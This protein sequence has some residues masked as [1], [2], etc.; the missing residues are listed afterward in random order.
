MYQFPGNR[1]VYLSLRRFHFPLNAWLSALHRIT[2]L[3][4]VICLIG[5]LMLLNLLTFHPLVTLEAI[6]DHWILQCLHTT[7]WIS[8]SYHWLAGLRHLL[9]E[10]FT[11]AAHYAAINSKTVSRIMLVVWSALSLLSCYAVWGGV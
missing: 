11:Q 10:H 7:F 1:P 2:G 6:R 8:L 9:A 4:L 5:Y 3:L